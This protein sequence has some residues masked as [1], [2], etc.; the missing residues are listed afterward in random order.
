MALLKLVDLLFQVYFYLIF[1]KV[2]LSWIPDLRGGQIDRFIS[3]YVDPYL[4][5]FRGIIPPIGMIDISP[6]VAIFALYFIE[7]GVK[8]LI[9]QLFI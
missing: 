4:N 7:Y 3:Y 5:L 8:W 6:I 9:I 2:L 1:G